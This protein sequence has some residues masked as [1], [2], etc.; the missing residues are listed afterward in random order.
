[1]NPATIDQWFPVE[2]QLK[3]V[4]LLKGRVGITRRR[5]EYFVRLWAYLLL[6]QQQ[7]LGK[8]IQ[9]P[10]TQLELPE[11]FVACSHREAYE[12]FYGQNNNGRGSDRSAG[13]MIDQLVALGLIEK[14]FDGNT[15]CIRIRSSLPN[16]DESTS[17]EKSVQLVPDNFDHRIDTIP[18]ANFLARA[19]VLN[20][21][22]TAAPH[23]IA[24]ILRI[25]A[26]Q[27]PTGMRVLRRCDNQ[28]IVGFYSLFPTAK[29]SEKN[30]FL[31]PRKSLYLLSSTRETDPYKLA[32]PG[33]LSCTSVYNRAWQIDTPYQQRVNICQFLEDSKKTLMQ[34]QADF[35]NLCDLYTIAIDP[36]NEQFASALGFQKNSYNS[37]RSL[38]WMYVPLDKYLALDIE[39][40]MSVL[41]LA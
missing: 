23:R 26:E 18:V 40:A 3:Y 4:S 25:W 10:L 34:M 32:E 39:Q 29:E 20:R 12:I 16:P 21:R 14:D 30:F 11:G 13:L 6:K 9:R 31:P 17:T 38:F 35:P 22:T 7:E 41:R 2:Q 37:E 33:D 5:A 8:R 24:R 28:H 15:T 36:A 27:Y 19:F 1:M